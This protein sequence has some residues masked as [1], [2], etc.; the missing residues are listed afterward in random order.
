M[1]SGS[2]S[3]NHSKSPH[4]ASRIDR[5]PSSRKSGGSSLMRWRAPWVDEPGPDRLK[6]SPQAFCSYASSKTPL[7]NRSSLP[8]AVRPPPPI[9]SGFKRVAAP[10][11]TGHCRDARRRPAAP[12]RARCGGPCVCKR[13]PAGL[14]Q[15]PETAVAHARAVHPKSELLPARPAPCGGS[16]QERTRITRRDGTSVPE[17]GTVANCLAHLLIELLSNNNRQ[18]NEQDWVCV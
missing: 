7:G 2:T 17:T 6:G 4:G 5:T 8:P 18:L 12:G 11:A 16:V 3:R 13:A 15:P 10:A 1:S 9:P 14:D